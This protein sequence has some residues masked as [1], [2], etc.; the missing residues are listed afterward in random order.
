[1]AATVVTK[2]IVR[3]AD[4]VTIT[5]EDVSEYKHIYDDGTG[6]ILCGRAIRVTDYVARRREMP[7][8]A[9]CGDCLA[10]YRAKKGA[11]RDTS[12]AG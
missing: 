10:I 11:D 5:W 12:N 8:G 6:T 3:F 7:V 2:D 4:R 9:M 1:M